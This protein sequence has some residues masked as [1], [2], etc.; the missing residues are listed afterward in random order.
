MTD[1]WAEGWA[2]LPVLPGL[3]QLDGTMGLGTGE[4]GPTVQGAE[5]RKAGFAQ[6]LLEWIACRC[7]LAVEG[8]GRGGVIVVFVLKEEMPVVH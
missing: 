5:E 4:R 2:S 7:W 6:L 8:G 1:S 3:T